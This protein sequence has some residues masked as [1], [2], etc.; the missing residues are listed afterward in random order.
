MAKRNIF[1]S[2]TVADLY[3]RRGFRN[4]AIAIYERL[5]QQ[6]PSNQ[7]LRDKLAELKPEAFQKEPPKRG[8]STEK[9]LALLKKLQTRV[10]QRRRD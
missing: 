3:F 8:R 7:Q 10:S 2:E 6:D 1:E 9:K 4:K 5:Y